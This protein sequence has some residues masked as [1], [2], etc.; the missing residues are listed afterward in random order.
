MSAPREILEPIDDHGLLLQPRCF[1]A[2]HRAVQCRIRFHHL[3]APHPVYLEITGT[4][5]E[6][7]GN[8]SH[9]CHWV[10]VSICHTIFHSACELQG[11]V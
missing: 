11:E 2:S 4:H 9:L 1:D 7:I 8:L 5:E 6:K 3:G 10:S